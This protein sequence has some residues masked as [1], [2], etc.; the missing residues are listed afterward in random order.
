MNT[1]DALEYYLFERDKENKAKKDT[2]LARQYGADSGDALGIARK[3]N[4]QGATR[5][6]TP[7]SQVARHGRAAGAAFGGRIGGRDNRTG[8]VDSPTGTYAKMS[9]ADRSAARKAIG[10][11]MTRAKKH[12]QFSFDP[13][14]HKADRTAKD[15][16]GMTAP[17]K[18]KG[19][20]P[21]VIAK[22]QNQ[23]KAKSS[24]PAVPINVSQAASKESGGRVVFGRYYDA[25]GN[26]L[27]RTQGG[28]W[29]DG[30]TDPNAKSQL[31]IVKKLSELKSKK[32]TMTRDQLK[33][34]IKSILKE[35]S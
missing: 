30:K 13:L 20:H 2:F 7:A 35:Y 34:E 23:L 16:R 3:S 9:K 27:G 28:Q 29:I 5:V 18:R 14:V 17:V 21:S 33:N 12:Q 31:E 26:Y 15:N 24:N 32:K 19:D 1:A 4:R 25:Q 6:D 10:G 22:Q 11:P 8:R